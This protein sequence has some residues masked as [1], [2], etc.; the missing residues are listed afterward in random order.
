L[1]QRIA[2]LTGG[3]RGIGAAIARRMASDNCFVHLVYRDDRA[4][5]EAVVTQIAGA[6]EGEARVLAHRADVSS[7]ED[8]CRLVTD[9]LA[10]SGAIDI[11]INNAGIIDDRLV[12]QTKTEAFTRLLEVNLTGPFMLCREVLPTML[13]AGWGR[14]I[15]IS[16]I[17]AAT[18]AP[19]QAGY[20]AAKAGLEGLTRALA[21]EVGHKGIRVNAVAPGAIET[22]MTREM[23]DRWR[24]M[25]DERPWGKPEH[26][27]GL[28]AFLASDDADFIAGR[29]LTVDGGRGATRP[30]PP[31]KGKAHDDQG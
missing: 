20:A 11:L 3:S 27:A 16:S 26:V 28:V 12:L 9:V 25:G 7:E 17:A 30:R 19:G 1:T 6:H 5:A 13:D 24:G 31:A 23:R 21:A 8:V 29:V 14:I 10:H 15:N 4:A 22:D 18:P 2:I